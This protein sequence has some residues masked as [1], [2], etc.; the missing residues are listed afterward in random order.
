MHG[1]GTDPCALPL[2]QRVLNE[3]ESW[4]TNG[5]LI[6]ERDWDERPSSGDIFVMLRFRQRPSGH[7][8]WSAEVLDRSV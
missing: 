4:S 6:S 5:C 7:V 8:R 3:V 1:V 2:A